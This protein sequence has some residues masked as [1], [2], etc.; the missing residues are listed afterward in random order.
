MQCRK[1]KEDK[2]VPEFRKDPTAKSGYTATCK[3]CLKESYK[4]SSTQRNAARRRW[5]KHKYNVN[6]DIYDSLYEQQEGRCKIC[7]KDQ[8][9]L[10][11]DHCHSGNNIRGLLCHQCNVGLGMFKDDPALL[12]AAIDYLGGVL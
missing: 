3:V 12:G 11:V 6:M 4:N 8:D 1:C 7:V 2:D 9:L 10:Y 5:I